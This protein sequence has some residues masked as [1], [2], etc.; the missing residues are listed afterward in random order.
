MLGR[1]R[2]RRA[3]RRYAA[4]R[5]LRRGAGDPWRGRSGDE[6]RPRLRAVSTI[7]RSRAGARSRSAASRGRHSSRRAC[8]ACTTWCACSRSGDASC[9]SASDGA[10]VCW[11]DVDARGHITTTGAHRGPT[12]VPGVDH[13]VALTARAAL[14]EHG[15][16]VHVARRWHAGE[17]GPG[18]DGA[19]ELRLTATC[20]L[21]ADGSVRCFGASAPCAPPPAKPVVPAKKP[22]IRGGGHG[23]RCPAAEG[24]RADAGRAERL[25]VAVRRARVLHL[26]FDHGL[27]AVTAARQ[28]VCVDAA[29]ACKLVRPWPAFVTVQ[30]SAGTCARLTNGTVRCG[31]SDAAAPVI[32]GVAPRDGARREW[33]ERMRARR[34]WRCRVLDRHGSRAR[35]ACY[36]SSRI[37]HTALIAT[38]IASGRRPRVNRSARPM[39]IT[40]SAPSTPASTSGASG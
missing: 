16:V 27:C 1:Q 5:E 6:R 28:L 8:P 31:G 11:G 18:R 37:S 39:A 17:A 9:A 23:R 35:R 26:A 2:R 3:R 40:A 15:D 19:R 33:A 29:A 10:L 25:D 30:A 34:Q 21:A 22:V 4:R 36:A 38:R 20:A 7:T 13:V 14:R 32:A 24:R 12:P